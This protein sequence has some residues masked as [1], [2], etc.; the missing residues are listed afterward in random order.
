MFI[1]TPYHCLT[2]SFLLIFSLISLSYFFAQFP[3]APQ[4]YSVQPSLASLGP[5]TKANDI[6]PEDYYSG[7]AYVTL[8]FGNVR[9]WL[10]GPEAGKKIVLI[11][12]LSI[13]SLIWKDVAPA[14]A[15]RGYRVLLY[16]LYGRGYSD[17][18]ETTYDAS[19]YATQLAL[20]MQHVKWPKAY[21]AG[22]SMG[23]GI[24]AAFTSFFPDLVDSKVALIAPTGLVESKDL[25]KTTKFM[26][27]PFVQSVTSSAPFRFYLRRLAN[28]S[29]S[30][31]VSE[32]VRIQSAHLPGYNAAIASSLRDGPIRGL[33]EAFEK[34]GASNRKILLIWGTAD[35]A[36]PY[37]YAPRIQRLLPQSELITVEG[38]GHDLAVSHP[39]TIVSVFTRFFGSR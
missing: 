38:G 11:H 27:S 15:S 32:I 33:H 19:L 29:S 18:P 30:D 23:G 35:N 12:G 22:V 26:S 6:Y 17:A 2:S 25:S 39:E 31:P 1:T 7:G 3:H 21:V 16:D 13:P 24:L 9:Y 20:L 34:L 8:P 28:A 4:G 37:K 36:V 10:L 14:L 5:E